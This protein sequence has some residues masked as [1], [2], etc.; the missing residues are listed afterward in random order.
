VIVGSGNQNLEEEKNELAGGADQA[1]NSGAG[2]LKK[3]GRKPKAD[4]L[5]PKQAVEEKQVIEIPERVS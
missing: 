3:R 4:P 1:E 2:Q 5:S